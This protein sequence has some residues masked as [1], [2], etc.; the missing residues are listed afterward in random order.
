MNTLLVGA[1]SSIALEY[2]NL[3]K[4]EQKIDRTSRNKEL[5]D[6]LFLDVR[7]ESSYKNLSRTYDRIIYFIG[8]TPKTSDIF[9]LEELKKIVDLNYTYSIYALEYMLRHNLKGNGQLIVLSSVA[10]IRGRALNFEY[11]ASKAALG[12]AIQGLLQK[13]RNV[14]ITEV[15]LGPVYTK[16]VPIHNTP[17]ILISNPVEIAKKLNVIPVNRTSKFIP[18]YWMLIMFIIK[19]IPNQFYRKLKF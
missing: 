10:S 12:V 19:L 17:A 1:T 7:D 14:N 18:T 11:G 8:F 16:S 3:F 5:K 13:Y 2:Y 6:F 4:E 9:S 15:K